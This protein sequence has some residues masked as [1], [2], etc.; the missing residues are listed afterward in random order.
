MRIL[1]VTL[2]FMF[3]TNEPQQLGIRPTTVDKDAQITNVTKTPS[4]VYDMKHADDRKK[5]RRNV[6]S[7][8]LYKARVQP[9]A[10]FSSDLQL[11]VSNQPIS[12]DTTLVELHKVKFV[13]QSSSGLF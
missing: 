4:V 3:V 9:E 11:P 12:L 13:K 7:C 6:I 5:D 8:T 1:S 2:G 10:F